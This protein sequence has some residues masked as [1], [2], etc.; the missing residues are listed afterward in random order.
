MLQLWIKLSILP[1]SAGGN[2]SNTDRKG[3]ETDPGANKDS[4]QEQRQCYR[5]GR[6]GHFA[7][8]C[9]SSGYNRKSPG[10]Y[11]AVNNRQKAAVLS[12]NVQDLYVKEYRCTCTVEGREVELQVDAGASRTLVHQDLTEQSKIDNAN[13]MAVHCAHGDVITYPTAEILIGIHGKNYQVRA[14]VSAT[15]SRSVLLGR[16]VGNLL[17]LAIK[18]ER[19]L[20]CINNIADAGKIKRRSYTPCERISPWS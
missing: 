7:N 12:Y 14:G 9:P 11:F 3:K 4:H 15:L 16:D 6:V 13:Q 17:K 8:Q 18:E 20:R 2:P 5:S 10:A 1:E 19:D